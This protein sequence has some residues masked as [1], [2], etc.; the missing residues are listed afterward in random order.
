M[1]FSYS[2]TYLIVVRSSELPSE[3]N[4]FRVCNKRAAEA[5]LHLEIDPR[6]EMS[7]YKKEGGRS[8]CT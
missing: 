2:H 6:G 3:I 1:Q 5:G 8:P 7:I 4:M